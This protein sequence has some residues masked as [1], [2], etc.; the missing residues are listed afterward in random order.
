[1]LKH[2][3]EYPAITSK[4]VPKKILVRTFDIKLDN[5]VT[6]PLGKLYILR[7]T[8][9]TNIPAIAI[10]F[11]V[12]PCQCSGTA[13]YLDDGFCISGYQFKQVW[14]VIFMCGCLIHRLMKAN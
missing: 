3:P 14:V 7:D 11:L 1:M 13:A 12:F 5:G 8:F 2:I 4:G 10:Y 6:V 9:H